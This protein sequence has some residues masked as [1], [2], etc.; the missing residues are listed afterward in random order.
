MDKLLRDMEALCKD[1]KKRMKRYHNTDWQEQQVEDEE[2]AAIKGRDDMKREEKLLNLLELEARAI[3]ECRDDIKKE[4]IDYMDII[5]YLDTIKY[6]DT[7]DY[8]D[9]KKNCNTED[10][11]RL[12]EAEILIYNIEGADG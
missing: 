6:M 1:A 4:W 5:D 7:V 8:M 3:K 12:L 11:L 2:M 10:L 9:M